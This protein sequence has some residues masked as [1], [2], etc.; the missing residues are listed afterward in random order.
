MGPCSKWPVL[1]SSFSEHVPV[2]FCFCGE[3]PVSV[4]DGFCRLKNVWVVQMI[5]IL[6]IILSYCAK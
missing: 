6:V 2:K 3:T 5:K 4:A 1:P